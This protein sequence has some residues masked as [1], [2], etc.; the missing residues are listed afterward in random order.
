MRFSN[1]SSNPVSRTVR[2]LSASSLRSASIFESKSA[3]IASLRLSAGDASSKSTELATLATLEA[4][5]KRS[6]ASRR[7]ELRF[8]QSIDNDERLK[9]LVARERH[10]LTVVIPRYRTLQVAFIDWMERTLRW[11]T[12]LPLL[13]I[14]VMHVGVAIAAD[15]FMVRGR[16]MGRRPVGSPRSSGMVA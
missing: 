4:A 5:G 6:A 9:A 7:S 10:F 16:R 11:D 2:T 13:F 3:A 8:G 14:I 15:I 12:L 1:S